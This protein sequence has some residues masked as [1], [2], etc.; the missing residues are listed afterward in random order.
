MTVH[1]ESEPVCLLIFRS[2]LDSYTQQSQEMGYGMKKIKRVI[3]IIGIL[4]MAVMC[5]GCTLNKTS[6]ETKEQVSQDD[7]VTLRALSIGSPPVDG[8]DAFY[9]TL[10][11]L[12]I[13]DLGCIVRYDFIPW[14]DERKQINIAIESGEYDFIPGGVFSD[15]KVMATKNAFINLYDYMD[16]VPELISHYEQYREDYLK[17]CEIDGKLY[18]LPQYITGS[19][20]GV[21]EGFLYREDLRKEWGLEPVTDFETME[22]YLYRAKQDERYQDSPLITDNRIWSCLWYMLAGNKYLEVSDVL[23]TPFVVTTIE[24]PYT[25]V[26]RFETPEFQQILEIVNQWYQDGIL[27]SSILASS[28]NEGS[29]G[30]EM[31]KQ[32]QK[33]CE[34]NTTLW[35]MNRTIIKEL[36]EINPDWEYGYYDYQLGSTPVYVASNSDSTV[37]SI[38]SKSN[39]PEIAIKF[40]EKVHTDQQYFDL[41]NYGVEGIHYNIID[42]CLNYAGIDAENVF[43]GWTGVGDSYNVYEIKSINEQWQTEVVDREEERAEAL[44]PIAS[45]HPLEGFI[46]DVS[47]VSKEYEEMEDIRVK[48]LQP[49]ACG[50]TDNISADYQTAIEKLKETGLEEY[51]NEVQFQLDFFKAKITGTE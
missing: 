46:F 26:S 49:I 30:I 28:D 10:D 38:S 22:A 2:G 51:L 44:A 31:M 48:Y 18:G 43:P 17:N 50:V 13:P 8:M 23:D 36:Y 27:Q 42:S 19:L 21:G 5:T 25:V 34:T 4:S 41:V 9:E 47:N 15:Y 7:I 6:G 14:G 29:L 32:D 1:P 33:P 11:A 39:F 12:T 20:Y 35:V 3:C 24:D 16:L 40:L 37:I 45:R